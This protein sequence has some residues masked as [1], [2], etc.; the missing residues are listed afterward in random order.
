MINTWKIIEIV[1]AD[2]VVR[3]SAAMYTTVT[4]VFAG[5]HRRE[6]YFLCLLADRK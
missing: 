4:I 1:K 2:W 6:F 5:E 3:L